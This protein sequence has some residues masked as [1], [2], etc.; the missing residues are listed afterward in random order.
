MYK[1]A[2]YRHINHRQVNSG[3]W[4]CLKDGKNHYNIVK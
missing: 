4:K 3:E 2:E 1:K